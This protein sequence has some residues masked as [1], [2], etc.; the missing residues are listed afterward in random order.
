[1]RR[2][3]FIL[4]F[5]SSLVIGHLDAQTSIL[6]YSEN[7]ENGAPGTQ[8]N[9]AGNGSNTGTNMWVINNSYN[10]AS[11]FPNTPNQNQVNGGTISFAPNSKYLHIYNQP[12]GVTNCNYDPTMVSD[13]FVQFG[14]GFCTLGLSNVRMTFFYIAEGSP[15]AYGELYYSINNGPWTTTGTQLV[16]QAIWQYT[17]V[18]N[19][20]FDN[21]TSLRF[22]IQWI[23]DA[24]SPPG[25]MSCGI[26]DIFIA[27]DF[28]NFITQFNV[29]IDSVE[30]NP[31]CQNFGLMIYYHL[32]VP[33]CGAGF[34]EIQ[35]SDG[36]GNFPTNPTSLGIYQSSNQWMNGILWPTIPSAT[37][38]DSCYKIRIHYYYTDYQLNFYANLN[39]CIIVQQCP[40]TINTLQPV[41][42][43]GGDSV[44]V[45]SVIDVPF[46]S[47]GVFQNNN[48]YIAEL[49]D[50]AGN[51]PPNCNVLGSSP[52]PSSY[53]PALGS[54][55]GS[56][57]GQ[58]NEN[59]QP[60]QDGCGYYIR[61]RSTNP[62]TIGMVWGPFCIRHCDIETN[63]KL[64][65]Q[66]CIS[67]TQGFDTTVYVNIH[68]YDSSA[69]YSPPNQF[70]LEVHESQY[71]NV[72]NVGGLG[73]V[74]ATSD[75]TIQLHIPPV[76]GLGA[77]GLQPGMYYVR[78]IATNSSNTYDVLGTLIHLTIGAPA[79]NLYIWQTPSDSVL[80][81]GDAVYFYPIPYNAG[82]PM[83]SSYV[84]YLN[85]FVFSTE[86]AIGILFNGAGN[87][88]LTVQ[89]TNYGCTGPVVP[90]SVS[91]QVLGP[92]NAPIIGPTQVCV[93][94]TI[95]Y[96]AQFSPNIYYEWSTTGG[97]IVDTANNE[98]YIV[99]DTPGV[100]T[101]YLMKLNKCGQAIGS[102]NVIVSEHP[103][104]S[105]TATPQV[106]TGQS[107]LI[108]YTGNGDPPL[109]FGWNFDGGIPS[110][111]GNNPGPHNVAWSTPGQYTVIVSVTHYGC[112]S[113]DSAM[114]MVLENP[115]AGFSYTGQCALDSIMFTNTTQGNLLS[116]HWYFG[117][118]SS[119]SI[120]NNPAHVY[121]SSGIYP[122]QLIVGASNGCSDTTVQN[123]TVD[124]LPTSDFVTP[125]EVCAG[126]N[127]TVTYTGSGTPGATFTWT[128]N[129]GSI[130]SG[131]GPGPYEISWPGIGNYG[132]SLTVE[133][134]GC[135]SQMT[136]DSVNVHECLLDIPNVFT[137]NGDGANDLFVI[138][139]LES[140]KH[141][142]ILIFNRWGNLVYRNDEYKNDWTGEDHSDG[143][144][145]YVLIMLNGDEY[146]GTITLLR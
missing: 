122:V 80:C 43:M 138:K 81:I 121:G 110:P 16:N 146:H 71:F 66:A 112:T 79:D 60:I 31:I 58:V 5:I 132:I 28:D 119:D 23:N 35:L 144:Y 68:F 20:A 97:G 24:G 8:L 133:E 82:P 100:Y 143:V 41:V 99:F 85:G 128:F 65:I 10:G 88:N 135:M 13:R 124:P 95:Y 75:T 101:I 29:V 96:H 131:A 106:C 30:P 7:F 15:T 102:K 64:D 42:T 84:W 103:N 109:I 86:P 118:G 39:V 11:Q 117:D 93:G 21:V 6:V 17:I 32:T 104:A 27:G 125:D 142:K 140:Y 129:G 78:V 137:P 105:F 87:F 18:Q 63:H 73:S 3:F 107:S 123:V 19:A 54:P 115:A 22:G 36:N 83:N 70:L 47:T 1:M 34:F 49:S 113:K 55:P 9:V 126:T 52:D 61:V 48:V 33:L 50:S 56:V 14:N 92:P 69:V 114:I 130:V 12:S 90:N 94:D 67:S 51:F 37:P 38:A 111:G 108:T 120:S 134:N 72:V 141:S 89:E 46:F 145:Y 45:G 25:K 127:S 26:D 76:S 2:S 57:S 116:T 4:C 44:C 139:G 40:N 59:N 91:L 74:T 77:L 98:L 136:T 62:A 53:D